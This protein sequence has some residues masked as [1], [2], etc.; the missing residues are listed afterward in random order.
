MV[1][2]SLKYKV[3]SERQRGKQRAVVRKEINRKQEEKERIERERDAKRTASQQNSGVV[4]KKRKSSGSKWVVVGKGGKKLTGKSAKEFKE[5]I[6][7]AA[8]VP[9]PEPEPKKQQKK[10][11]LLE[12]LKARVEDK[13]KPLDLAALGTMDALMD[14]EAEQPQKKQALPGWGYFEE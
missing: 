10:K 6:A 3:K 4:G 8:G 13:S 2:S 12:E 14:E 7:R 5:S 9:M 1:S 11:P